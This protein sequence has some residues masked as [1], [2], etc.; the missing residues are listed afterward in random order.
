MDKRHQ[1]TPR[2]AAEIAPGPTLLGA[3]RFDSRRRERLGGPGLR[4]FATIA[5]RWGLSEAQ[6]LSLLGFPGR[7]T[8]H[9]WLAKARGHQKLL[10][11]V[12]TLLRISAVLGIHK[13]LRILFGREE[14]ECAWLT[15]PHDA[16]LFGGQPPLALVVNGTQDGL[17]LVRRYLDAWRGGVFAAPNAADRDSAPYTDDDIILV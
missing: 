15:K 6:R 4:S 7:S 1:H 14:D 9:Q 17:M 5:E 3:A 10:L 12:D 11:P 16:P 8:Y 2:P 13:G